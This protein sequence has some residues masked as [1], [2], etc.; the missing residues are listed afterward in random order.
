MNSFVA[1]AAPAVAASPIDGTLTNDGFFPDIDLS[2]LRDAMRLDGTVTRERLR[3]AARDAMLTVNDELAAWRA[4]QR[5]AGAASLADVPA[6]RLDGESVH[7]FRYRRAVYHLAHADVTEKYRGF[8]STKSGGQVAAELA[9][10]VDES[11]RNARWAISD[12]L[13]IARSTVELI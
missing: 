11:R 12:I 10:T 9:A 3:H 8:D 2:A 4:R 13:G 5:A 6:E 7:V 1:T